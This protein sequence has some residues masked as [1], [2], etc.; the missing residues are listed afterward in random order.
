VVI[1]VADLSC[2]WRRVQ[3]LGVGTYREVEAFVDVTIAISAQQTAHKSGGMV[4][5]DDR[6]N[7]VMAD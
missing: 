5:I 3:I 4:V 6:S 7:F 1:R 2:D